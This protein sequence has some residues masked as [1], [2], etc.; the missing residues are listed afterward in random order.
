[1]NSN[2]YSKDDK[3]K[4]KNPHLCR[5]PTKVS[6]ILIDPLESHYLVPNTSI[7]RD[8]FSSKG[9]EPQWTKSAD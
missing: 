4:N 7:T 2:L 1:M 8:I 6:D 9:Q 5:V 3:L